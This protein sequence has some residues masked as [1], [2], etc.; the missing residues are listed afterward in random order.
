[1]TNISGSSTEV[2]LSQP[3][4]VPVRTIKDK[5][6]RKLRRL[7]IR[8]ARKYCTRL[9]PNVVKLNS[10]IV[11][12]VAPTLTFAEAYALQ[13]VAKQTSVPV[14]RLIDA[15]ES[16]GVKFIVMEYVNGAPLSKLWG[17]MKKEEKSSLLRELRQYVD[18]LRNVPPPRPG[19]VGALDYSPADD[20]RISSN[21]MGPF[22]N[23]DA[24][25]LF[26]R[27]GI[28]NPTVSPHIEIAL[29]HKRYQHRTVLTHGD[30]APQ[31]I[32]VNNGKIVA[33]IDWET[34][35]WFPEYWEYSL[36]WQSSWRWVEWRRRLGEFLD[37]YEAELEIEKMRLAVVE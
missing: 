23:H 31:N 29:A 35:G 28:E 12:K 27:W 14:P 17:K 30:L 20:E 7:A 2:V 25:H 13:Y 8:Y 3:P 18:E 1:M 10:G 6:T 5:I 33:I 16:K 34:S 15:Y 11:V 21:P 26:L 36:A 19:W 37:V 24:F 9:S 4:Q 32:I 22:Q